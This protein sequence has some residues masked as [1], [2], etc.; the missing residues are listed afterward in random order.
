MAFIPVR[1]LQTINYREAAQAA[2]VKARDGDCPERT[3]R[4][5]SASLTRRAA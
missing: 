5:A 4:D 2:Q 1:Y 3:T